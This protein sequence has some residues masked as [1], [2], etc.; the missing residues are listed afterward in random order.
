MNTFRARN[1]TDEHVGRH[2]RGE[3]VDGVLRALRP[4]DDLAVEVILDRHPWHVT[5]PAGRPIEVTS[6]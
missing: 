1:L 4:L 2:V 5:L 3:G 6:P